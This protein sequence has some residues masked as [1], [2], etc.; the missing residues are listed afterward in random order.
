MKWFDVEERLPDADENVLVAIM[1]PDGHGE[2]ASGYL[3]LPGGWM[4]C[5]TGGAIYGTVTH[6]ARPDLPGDA[7]HDDL[8]QVDDQ[9]NHPAHYTSHPSGIECIQVTEHMTFNCGNAVKYL[10]RN[11]L[12]DGQPAVQD[13]RKA[14]WYIEREIQRVEKPS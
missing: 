8:E 4:D 14:V 13:L 1:T 12:K 5:A 2:W 3:G 7:D 11:G 10:W 6:W 9:V